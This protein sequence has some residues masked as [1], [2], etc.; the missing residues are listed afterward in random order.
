MAKIKRQF[1]AHYIDASLTSTATYTRLGKDLEEY[2]VEMNAEVNST[3]NILGETSKTISSYEAQASVEPFYADQDD[4]MFPKLQKIIDDRLVLDDLKTTVLDV[5]L[6][7]E[8]EETPGTF[9]A[10][11]EDALI[12]IASYGGDSTGYQ[13]SFN[14]HNIGGRVKG[15]FVAATKTFTQDA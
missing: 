2:N 6:W 15:T 12:E 8:D 13:I 11:R 10:Y 4:P 5:H 3:Q 9:V 7:E 1:M 14:V